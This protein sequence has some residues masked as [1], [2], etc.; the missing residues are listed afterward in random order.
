M[1]LLMCDN[2]GGIAGSREGPPGQ[3]RRC[4]GIRVQHL[5]AALSI[6]V[7]RRWLKILGEPNA[8]QKVVW[9]RRSMIP[10]NTCQVVAYLRGEPEPVYMHF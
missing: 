7:R 6:P 1:L 10:A 2:R 5:S 4:S 3:N 9:Y 8:S